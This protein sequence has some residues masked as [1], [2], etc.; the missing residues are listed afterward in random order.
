MSHHAHPR[1][2]ALA[3]ASLL[4]AL[5]APLLP[6]SANAAP[7]QN[8]SSLICTPVSEGS[9]SSGTS[10]GGGRTGGSGSIPA[11]AGDNQG[12][13]GGSH[14]ALPS[15]PTRSTISMA[16]EARSLATLPVPTVHTAPEGKTY[17]R[18]RTALWVEGFVPVSTPPVSAGDQT[19]QATATPKSVTWKLGE[20]ELTCNGPGSRDGSTCSYTYKRSSARQPNGAYQVTATITWGVEWTCAGS[21]CDAPGGTLDDMEMTSTPYQLTVGEIQTNSRP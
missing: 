18:V 4:G 8:P 2:K 21:E 14:D 20:T 15:Q 13:G 5:T 3:G 16:E 11:V 7:C 10:G 12:F 19:V 1:L 17:V 6:A 9:S